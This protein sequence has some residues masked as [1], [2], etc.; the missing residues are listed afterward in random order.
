MPAYDEKIHQKRKISLLEK[1]KF[2]NDVVFIGTWSPKK[3]SFIKSIIH[4]GLNIKIY[5]NRWGN[6]PNI[7]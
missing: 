3:G 7:I 5:G 6:D 1:K 4:L 2:Q